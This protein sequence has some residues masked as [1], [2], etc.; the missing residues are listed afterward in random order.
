MRVSSI[1]LSA[2]FLSRAGLAL[3]ADPLPAPAAAAASAEPTAIAP[4]SAQAPSVAPAN[5]PGPTAA[6]ADKEAEV[7]F[8]AAP[9]PVTDSFATDEGQVEVTGARA[10]CIERRTVLPSLAGDRAAA[11]DN[12]RAGWNLLANG[13]AELLETFGTSTERETDHVR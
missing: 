10:V 8:A 4:A 11:K 5:T 6:T 3:A 7:K 1:A 2:W 13:A 12:G 9:E